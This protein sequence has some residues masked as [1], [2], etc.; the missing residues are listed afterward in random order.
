MNLGFIQAAAP[1]SQPVPL[2]NAASPDAF[3]DAAAPFDAT[4]SET[5]AGTAEAGAVNVPASSNPGRA[6]QPAWLLASM[7]TAMM[8]GAPALADA[9]SNTEVDAA[10]TGE[11]PAAAD[12]AADGDEPVDTAETAAIVVPTP[13]PA[14]MQPVPSAI[15][16]PAAGGEKA[17]AGESPAAQNAVMPQAQNA[18][19]PQAQ[20]AAM[21]QAQNAAMPPAQMSPAG[22][23][24]VAPSGPADAPA[25]RTFVTNTEPPKA[26]LLPGSRSTEAGDLA[27]AASAPADIASA[28]PG[29]GR[30]PADVEQQVSVSHP[31]RSTGSAR[32]AL[33]DVVSPL[34]DAAR[35]GTARATTAGAQAAVT[36]V[37]AAAVPAVSGIETARPQRAESTVAHGFAIPSQPSAAGQ[38]APMT[39]QDQSNGQG[40]PTPEFMRFAAALAQVN[41]AAGEDAGHAPAAPV[42]APQTAASPNVGTPAAAVVT[43]PAPQGETPGPEN[44]GRL[45]QAMRV[46]ARPGA[47]EANVRLNP[48]HLGDVSIAIR[49]ERN[50]VSA[51]VNAEGAGVRQW[52]ESQED[53]VRSGM[54]E[55]GLQ[56]DRFIVQR[57]GQRRDA[58]P[59][60]QE[61]PQGRRQSAR[62]QGAP[63]ERFEVVV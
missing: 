58:Q 4:L 60:Q 63:T 22:A 38:D 20:N 21:P 25:G 12:A 17:A 3:E 44:V 5:L 47:W 7:F 27:A 1:A 11:V 23:D 39:G 35:Q 41:P 31:P 62:R 19:M 48:E 8:T 54:A 45:V 9:A 50:T 61:E 32:A 26:G 51:V 10:E 16:L 6:T 29:V 34:P 28:T 18:A 49:V 55:H 37:A 52:L 2:T 36:D 15:A 42:A 24:V 33:G 56:L 53:A 13:W 59:Q 40:R 30:V 14:D 43:A 46:I 57:D